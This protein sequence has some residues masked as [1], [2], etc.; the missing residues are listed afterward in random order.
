MKRFKEYVLWIGSAIAIA[1]LAII[2]F[3]GRLEIYVLGAFVF[4]IVVTLGSLSVMAGCGY[5]EDERLKKI[6]AFS[7]MNSW[8]TGVTL[9]STVLFLSYFNWL[10]PLSAIQ[11]MS[12]TIAIMLLMFYC[13]YAYYSLKGDVE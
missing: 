5:K 7:L 8:V 4:G 11:A 12:L 3:T 10:G 13:W 9:L 1:A 2:F 6:A